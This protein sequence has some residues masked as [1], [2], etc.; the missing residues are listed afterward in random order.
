MRVKFSFGVLGCVVADAASVGPKLA[1]SATVNCDLYS[2][3]EYLERGGESQFWLRF[4]GCLRVSWL[5]VFSL[6]IFERLIENRQLLAEHAKSFAFCSGFPFQ[7]LVELQSTFDVH[8]RSFVDSSLGEV[9]LLAHHSNFHERRFF[10]PFVTS[11]LLPAAI[12]GESKFSNRSTLRGVSDFGVTGSVSS[13]H[14]KIQA[15][16]D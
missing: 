16:H 7:P 2:W 15:V 13:D 3:D 6:A 11:S 4:G 12:D 9:G 5:L 14:N 1:A 8:R 10:P